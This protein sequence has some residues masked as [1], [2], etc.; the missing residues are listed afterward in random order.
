ME[1]ARGRGAIGPGD[2]H[3]LFVRSYRPPRSQDVAHED[4]RIGI[5]AGGEEPVALEGEV[6]ELLADG[7][8]GGVLGRGEMPYLGICDEKDV[9]GPLVGDLAGD[10]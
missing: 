6:E 2:K 1:R 3:S 7:A 9:C 10:A 8:Q 5:A 4:D